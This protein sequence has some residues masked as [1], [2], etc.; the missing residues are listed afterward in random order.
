MINCKR[1]KRSNTSDAKEDRVIT[2]VIKGLT[3][4]MKVRV[5]RKS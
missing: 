3:K 4:G 5:S 1:V 2:Q